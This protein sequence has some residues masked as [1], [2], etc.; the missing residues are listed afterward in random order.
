MGGEKVEKYL[1]I[2][3]VCELLRVSRQTV[4]E[5]MKRGKIKSLKIDRAVRIPAN[6]FEDWR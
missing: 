4:T 3:E 1:T 6:Q 2:N 5:W